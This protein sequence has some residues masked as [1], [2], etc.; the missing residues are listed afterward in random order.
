MKKYSWNFD[1]DEEIWDNDTFDT[2]EECI[3]AARNDIKS[4]I[5]HRGWKPTFIYIGMNE[6]FIP[7]VSAENILE[8]IE[9]D[10]Y[11]EFGEAAE[12]YSAYNP[13]DREELDEL[14][15][16]LNILIRDWMKKYGYYPNFWRIVDIKEYSL[17]I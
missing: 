15:E 10:A 1:K 11:D 14:D 16:K 6:P 7:Y 12:S 9:Q 3:E 2:I 17:V 13:K 5:H 8:G 4:D